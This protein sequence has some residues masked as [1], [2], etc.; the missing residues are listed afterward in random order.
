MAVANGEEEEQRDR[1]ERRA[2]SERL[3]QTH[4]DSPRFPRLSPSILRGASCACQEAEFRGADLICSDK[5][6]WYKAG[7]RGAA[8]KQ[9]G[10]NG[11]LSL[12]ALI[13]FVQGFIPLAS[14]PH[15]IS[16]FLLV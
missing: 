11:G 6:Q 9:S 7:R 1:S 2:G 5:G 14:S 16:L 3:L 8:G 10:K 12:Q 13:N 4:C 15:P